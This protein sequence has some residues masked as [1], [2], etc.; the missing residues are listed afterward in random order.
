M[1]DWKKIMLFIQAAYGAGQIESLCCMVQMFNAVFGED[2]EAIQT[3]EEF[4]DREDV[5]EAMLEW[6]KRPCDL[7]N[8]KK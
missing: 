8:N 2:K 5:S 1:K 3:L 4:T 6:H 7:D